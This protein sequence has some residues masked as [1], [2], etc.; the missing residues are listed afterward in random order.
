MSDT[1]RTDA[2]CDA[3]ARGEVND[4]TG[5]R[6]LCERLERENA[7]LRGQMRLALGELEAGRPEAVKVLLRAP[8][9]PPHS[10]RTE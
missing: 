1:P 2:M 6:T 10:E 5:L 8:L 4:Y 7:S 3:I 9:E